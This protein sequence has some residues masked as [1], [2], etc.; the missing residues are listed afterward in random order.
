LEVVNAVEPLQRIKTCPLG[1]QS[2]GSRLCPLHSRLDAALAAMEEAF[3][4]TTLA[5][6]LSE[7]TMSKP[8]CEAAQ[9][10]K[11]APLIQLKLKA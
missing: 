7:P 2:H 8:L 11:D 5:D 4:N 10:E 1:I 3:G 6:V 9:P